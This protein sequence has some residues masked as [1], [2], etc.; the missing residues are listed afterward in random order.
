MKYTKMTNEQL[1]KEC[2]EKVMG[3]YQ[4]KYPNNTWWFEPTSEGH[5]SIAMI[6]HWHPTANISQAFEIVNKMIADGWVDT[7][8]IY[9]NSEWLAEFYKGVN[10]F[11]GGDVRDKSIS[12]AIV[13]AAIDAK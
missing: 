6:N 8:L 7:A 13:I 10:D 4:E 5:T 12:R 2:A 3:W 9:D 11:G 1:D